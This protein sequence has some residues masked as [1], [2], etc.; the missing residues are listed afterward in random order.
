MT[1]RP[2]V[3]LTLDA[4]EAGGRYTL[5]RAYA[6][7][8]WAAGGRPVPLVHCAPADAPALLD[9]V[10]ALVVT[11]GAFDVPP[12]LY[13]EER[14]PACGPEKPERTAAELALLRA[15]LE[16]G[17]PLLG[18]CGGMQLLAVA[19]GGTLWQDLT[20]DLG[21]A[22]HEQPPPKDR[23]SH[24]VAPVA[25]SLLAGLVGTE[26]LPVSSTHHQAVR[27]P[28]QGVRV[29]ARAPDGVIEALELPALPF[30]LGV[31][32]HPEALLSHD[33]RHLRLYQGLVEAARGR[34]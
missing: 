28:G 22:G 25:G 31:Q 1:P 27:E 13:G 17:L 8:A 18:V 34:R 2:R 15:A 21:L 24:Q 11:G 30:A 14:R 3:G 10:D 23:P 20:A 16:R 19:R 33:P 6:D 32:W 12:S 7:A 9:L 29:S 26:P 5:K 4:D